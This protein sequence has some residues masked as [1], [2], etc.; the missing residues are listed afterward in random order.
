M[1]RGVISLSE[2]GAE[3]LT[4]ILQ[5]CDVP[6]VVAAV[7][8]SRG[9]IFVG[10]E[11]K[12]DLKDGGEM[13]S[14]TIFRIFSCTKA[15]AGA[16]V[17]K[18]VETGRLDLDLPAKI[19]VPELANVKVITGFDDDGEPQLRAPKQ[20]ITTRMLMLHTAGFGYAFFNDEYRRLSET[21]R[22]ANIINCTYESIKAPLLFDPGENWNYGLNL[23]WAGKVVEAVTGKSLGLALNELILE[24]LEMTETT[25]TLPSSKRSRLATMHQRMTNGKL[26]PTPEVEFPADPESHMAGHGLYAT[27]GDYMK[28]IRMLLN[29]GLS[30]NGTRVLSADTVAKMAENGL[31]PEMKVGAFT[32]TI[33][34]LSNDVEFFP[35]VSKSWALTFMTN[36]ELAPTGRSA[37]SLG[38]TGLANLFY[39]IDR[40]SGIGGFWATQI[41][42]FGDKVS[43]NGWMDFEST[44][45]QNLTQSI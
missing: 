30:D 22:L 11:G 40:K 21:G 16:G 15:I 20:D 24:P 35:T 29:N 18:L 3:K 25:F 27:V 8:N 33:P 31:S 45:Y 44:V 41:F 13:T 10:A 19:Y 36:E 5:Q 34:E 12:R 38:W 9:N 43:L 23:D 14:D 28:F 1:D 32:G 6:G 39:W 42:P 2:S 4:T 26:V 17:M 37:G 7:T